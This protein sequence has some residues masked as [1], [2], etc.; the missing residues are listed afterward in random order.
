MKVKQGDVAL[1]LF[2]DSSGTTAK[3]RPVVVVQA[4][5]LN[6]GIDQVIVAM[7]TSKLH[8][9]GHGSR[10]LV[11]RISPLGQDMGLRM[12]SVIMTDNL[13]TVLDEPNIKVVGHMTEFDQVRA[14]LRYTLAI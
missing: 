5:N 9:S 2:P 7:I 14:A 12:D 1:V 3:Y 10:V 4:D 8:R 6:T 11:R 13:A